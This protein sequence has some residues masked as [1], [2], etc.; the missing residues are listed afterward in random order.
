MSADPDEDGVLLAQFDK[1]FDAPPLNPAVDD[2]VAMDVIADLAEISQPLP[3]SLITSAEI[4]NLFTTSNI[5]KSHNI[6]FE[7]I[8]EQIW[9]LSIDS[10]QY[11][12]TF[13]P[14]I[15]EAQGIRLISY[16]EPFSVGV[17]A[18]RGNRLISIAAV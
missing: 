2:L 9:N 7:L 15:S 3:L 16:G 5:L 11:K 14:A 10:H 13:D 8:G 12:F 6:N 18:P 17:A 1:I 4:E